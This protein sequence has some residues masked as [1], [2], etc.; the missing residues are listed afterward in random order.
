MLKKFSAKYGVFK[1]LDESAIM[2]M[3]RYH[4]PGNVREL[5]HLMERMSFLG[6]ST[7]ITSAHLALEP[8]ASTPPPALSPDRVAIEFAPDGIDLEAVEKRLIVQALELAEGN[9]SRAARLLNLGREA[10]RYRINKHRLG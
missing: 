7:V 4:W 8:V 10:L 2:S 6:E 9:V 1:K 5:R 3:K